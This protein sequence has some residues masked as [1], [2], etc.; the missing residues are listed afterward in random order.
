M[1]I[2]PGEKVLDTCAGSGIQ[3]IY[4]AKL[5]GAG[6]VYSCDINPYAVANIKLNAR[7]NNL[8]KIVTVFHADLFPKEKILFDVIVANQPYT[9]YKPTDIVGK[10]V[11]DEKHRTLKKLLND[12]PKYLKAKGRMYISWANF[13]DFEFFE[14]I[15][16]NYKY[17]YRKIASYKD[18][19]E[20]G[21]EFRVYELKRKTY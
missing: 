8:E 2:K 9:D 1:V 7:K 12:A 21:V 13:A 20:S 16:S 15:A 11:W 17:K 5:K 10:S 18:P 3:T 14:K 19:D 6:Q 4:A